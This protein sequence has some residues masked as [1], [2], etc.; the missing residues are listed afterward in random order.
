[1]PAP[2][3]AQRQAEQLA[4]T[5]EEHNYRYYVLA[6]PSV[7]D[8]QYDAL[9][10][11]LQKLEKQYP[12]LIMSSSPTQRVGAKPAKGFASVAHAVPM[13]SLDNAFDSD[14]FSAF[15]VRVQQRLKEKQAISYACEPKLDGV[16]ISLLYEKGELMRAATR[17]DG[18]AGENVTLNVRTISS[19]PLRLRGKSYP[20]LLEV[21]GEIYMPL[22]G[23]AKMNQALAQRK[24]KTFA[25]PRNAASGSLRQLDP[26]IT[27]KRPLAFFAYAV[28]QVKGGA[29]ADT[30]AKILQQLKHWGFPVPP[31]N[32]V[33]QGVAACEKY[34]QASMREREKLSFEIDGVVFKVNNL[35]LQKRLGFVSRAPRW[36]IAYKFP[37]QEKFTEVKA[38]EFQVGRTGAITPVARLKPVFVGGVTVSNA[39]LHNMGELW[40]KDVR[41]GDTVVVRRAGDVIPEVVRPVLEKRPAKT[42]KVRLPKRCPACGAEII[43]PEDEAA[44]RCM[45]GLYCPAQLREA[46]KHFVARKAMDIDGLGEK[47][48]ELLLEKKLIKDVAD[49]YILQ[50]EDLADLPRM[51]EKSADNLLQ[52][53]DKS[54]KTTLAKF[55][56]ALG[57]R[58][59]GQATALSL[60]NHFQDLT[61]LVKADES[62]L[63]EVTDVGPVVAENIVGFFRQQH[64]LEL[65]EKIQKN[66]VYW[67]KPTKV[68]VKN[69]PLQG[70]TFVITGTLQ[71]FS[72]EELKTKLQALGAKASSSISAKTNYIIVG[73]NP[74]SKYTKA[75]SLGVKKI[76]EKQLLLL[77]QKYS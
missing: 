56:Y 25:N 69:A 27:A 36:A 31:Q 52:A 72:R 11:E 67:P 68:S 4:K 20:P 61:A 46:I 65:I 9:L 71:H 7:S 14:E 50:K 37:A 15:D 21:R 75:K 12:E 35:E 62:M 8:A 66:G 42:Q 34:Y 23:F 30:H 49:I 74:G 2:K 22:K 40:R 33:V 47:V 26:Q 44:A 77:L 18:K 13:L 73:E 41:V 51:G 63:C 70:Q 3:D 1:M 5:L 6:D 38:I 24:E 53:I 60:A 58:E 59:V 28:G 76:D 43:K 48:V 39:T 16:A 29:L 45:G 54:K 55:L 19:I 64:N 57:I 32:K 10:R 17:G